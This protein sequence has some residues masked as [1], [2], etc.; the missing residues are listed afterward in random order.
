MVF[1]PG[2]KNKRQLLGLEVYLKIGIV[3]IAKKVMRSIGRKKTHGRAI[4]VFLFTWFQLPLLRHFL[5]LYK[6]NMLIQGF[7]HV[8]FLDTNIPLGDC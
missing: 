2:L 7:F 5:F 8:F 1:S 6:L 3:K 4:S